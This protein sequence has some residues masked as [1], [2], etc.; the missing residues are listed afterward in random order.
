MSKQRP[1]PSEIVTANCAIKHTQERLTPHKGCEVATEGS[2]LFVGLRTNTISLPSYIS[3]VILSIHRLMEFYKFSSL[4]A[5]AITKSHRSS[6]Q[7]LPT[8][9]LKVWPEIYN[10]CHN[11]FEENKTE[12]KFTTAHRFLLYKR[13]LKTTTYFYKRIIEKPLTAYDF[14]LPR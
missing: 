11:H 14:V 1:L 2:R 9:L 12:Y 10:T 5:I 3:S 6:N 7:E 13:R 4:K 8:K